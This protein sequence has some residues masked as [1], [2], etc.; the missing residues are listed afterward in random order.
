[1]TCFIG[2][3]EDGVSYIGADSGVTCGSIKTRAKSPKIFQK[4]ITVDTGTEKHQSLMLLG[5]AGTVQSQQLIQH[6]FVAP[7]WNTTTRTLDQYLVVDFADALRACLKASGNCTVQEGRDVYDSS[8]LVL[9]EGRLFCVEFA[10]GVVE[11][12]DAFATI[13]SGAAI[14]LGA[15]AVLHTVPPRERID[16]ALRA[17]CA[18]ATG[19]DLPLYQLQYPAVPDP[20]MPARSKTN[21][22]GEGEGVGVKSSVSLVSSPV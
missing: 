6:R 4:S 15:M 18:Y 3:V 10:F 7:V 1:M 17:A 9:L 2:L 19:C 11:S 21:G 5:L 22:E 14:A 16:A 12:G 20:S 13:G 8:M